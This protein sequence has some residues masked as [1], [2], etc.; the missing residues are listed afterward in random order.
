M[1]AYLEERTDSH[2]RKLRSILAEFSE[3]VIRRLEVNNSLRIWSLHT[4]EHASATIDHRK[5]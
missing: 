3:T 1:I 2:S 5:R 4:Q